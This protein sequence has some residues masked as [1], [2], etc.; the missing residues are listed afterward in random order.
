MDFINKGVEKFGENWLYADINTALVAIGKNI[1]VENY[2]EIGV[3]RGRSMAMLASQSPNANF[4]GFDMWIED[5]CGSENPGPEFVKSELE[6]V[7]YKG[8]I[9]LSMETLRK[10]FQNFLEKTL[11]Y[12]LMLLLLM[13]IIL[14]VEQQSI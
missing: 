13:V 5:Y 12:F 8:K 2:M 1:N 11:K 7:G 10:Q 3:R 9:S 6:K 4:Y 14:L